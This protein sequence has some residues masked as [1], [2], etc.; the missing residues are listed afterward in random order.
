M[1]KFKDTMHMFKKILENMHKCIPLNAPVQELD[2]GK[3]ELVQS[4]FLKEKT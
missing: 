3:Y 2:F 1:H 4:I